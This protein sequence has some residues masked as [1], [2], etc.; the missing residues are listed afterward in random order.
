MALALSHVTFVSVTLRV[1]TL[2]EAAQLAPRVIAWLA[3]LGL[4]LLLA[5]EE[6]L[7]LWVPFAALG[8]ALLDDGGGNER[9]GLGA[10]TALA[11]CS[12]M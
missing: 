8:A 12:H 3:T 5:V 10:H 11:W 9:V 1:F 7:G 6:P 4:A 2:V